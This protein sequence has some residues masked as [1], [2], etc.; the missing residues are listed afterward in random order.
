MHITMIDITHP[1][2]P[3]ENLRFFA[4]MVWALLCFTALNFAYGVMRWLVSSGIL[5]MDPLFFNHFR[6]L[7]LIIMCSTIVEAILV[8]RRGMTKGTR[9]KRSKAWVFFEICLIAMTAVDSALNVV[10]HNSFYPFFDFGAA[11]S[12]VHDT[13]WLSRLVG[14]LVDVNIFLLAAYIVVKIPMAV[15]AVLPSMSRVYVLGRRVHESLFGFCWVIIAAILIMYGDY[16]D[17]ALGIFYLVF[18]AFLIGRD[19]KDVKGLQFIKDLKER[20]G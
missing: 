8:H 1:D 13:A 10:K 18:G 20:K 17:G 6:N 9:E 7:F 4:F 16:F 11:Y 14:V 3:R 12:F 15:H 2:P 19:Y 5:I